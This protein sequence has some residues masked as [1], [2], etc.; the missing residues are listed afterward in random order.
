[1]CADVLVNYRILESKKN[2][3]KSI[4]EN[5]SNYKTKNIIS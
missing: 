3:I 5:E 4:Y 1:M 2:K